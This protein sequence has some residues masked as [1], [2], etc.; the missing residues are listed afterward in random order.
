[1]AI[2]RKISDEKAKEI[3]EYFSSNSENSTPTIA[4]EL[5]VSESDVHAV[6][7]HYLDKKHKQFL[8]K[9]KDGKH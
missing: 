1:M 3:I 2:P 6:L 9:Q 7:D 4:K 8:K 5:E